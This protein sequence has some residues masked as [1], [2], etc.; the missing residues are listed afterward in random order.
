MWLKGGVGLG[1]ALYV[2]SLA[3]PAPERRGGIL[4]KIP[5]YGNHLSH[6]VY[7]G[8]DY[9]HCKSVSYCFY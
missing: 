6:N 3:A 1:Y 8:H 9:G 2:L 4:A 7:Y 5:T